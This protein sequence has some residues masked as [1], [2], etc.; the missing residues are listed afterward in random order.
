MFTKSPTGTI[1][2]CLLVISLFLTPELL[3]AQSG[4]NA[5]SFTR[6][7]FGSRGMGMGNAMG[8]VTSEGIYAHYNPALA[9]WISGNQLDIGSSLM[10]F[11]R[12]LHTVNATFA[13]PPS[14]GLNVGLL[15]ANVSQ[16]DGRSPSGYHTEMLSTH[17]YQLFAAFGIAFTERVRFG[18]AV[19][20]HLANHHSDISNSTGAGFDLGMILQPTDHWRVGI[21][22]QDLLSK[23]SWNTT[24]L[25]GS[26]GG[27]SR[28]DEIPVRFRFSSSYYFEGVG[29]LLSSEYEVQK[30]EMIVLT[31]EVSESTMPPSTIMV[32][33]NKTSYGHLFRM[34]AAWYPHERITFRAGW[35]V[36]DLDYIEET[37][38]LSFGTSVHLPYDALRPSVDYAYVREP[39]GI[40]GIHSI[41]LRLHF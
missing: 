18:A 30:Q 40:A 15:N 7:G 16:I 34:G 8:T 3:M 2:F 14:A 31:E 25:Y 29:L 21:A 19:K 38:K 6:M 24:D 28:S 35:E 11:D 12:S 32:S 4:G 39:M 20:L 37:H 26:R 17:E 1:A 33:Q 23:Y 27:T 10:S 36:L 22:V 13:L 5:A 41:S 9:A